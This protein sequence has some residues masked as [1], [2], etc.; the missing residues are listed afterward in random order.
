MKVQKCSHLQPNFPTW[1]WTL[2]IAVSCEEKRPVDS[3]SRGPIKQPYVGGFSRSIRK[4]EFS[5]PELWDYCYF[6]SYFLIC[7]A[8]NEN[9][10]N[11]QDQLIQLRGTFEIFFRIFVL[12]V[13][14]ERGF[15]LE[16]RGFD[17]FQ[18]LEPRDSGPPRARNSN[19]NDSIDRSK[20]EA[21]S[22][23]H[24]TLPTIYSV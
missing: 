5:T 18:V 15:L 12:T 1:K 2:I 6:L 10:W 22:Y 19:F 11:L 4:G 3:D 8:S 16:K 20:W 14:Q 7:D 24:L 17:T 23:T 13:L 9:F 21:V